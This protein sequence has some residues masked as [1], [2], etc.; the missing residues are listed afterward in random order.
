MKKLFYLLMFLIF[1]Q[2]SC[3]AG[4]LKAIALNDFTTLDNEATIKIYVAQDYY[5]T[6]KLL[7][8][9]GSVLVGSI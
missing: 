4:S 2:T 5:L 6:T 7:I 8:P 3:Y 1:F 9:E